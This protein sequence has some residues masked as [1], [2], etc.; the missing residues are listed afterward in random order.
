MVLCQ[1]CKLLQLEDNFDSNEMYGDD[2]GYMSSLNKSMELHLKVK[3]INLIKKYNLKPKNLIL[4]IGSNDGTF[5]SFFNKKFRLFGCDPTIKKFKNLYRK[6]IN[7]LPYFFSKDHFNNKKYNVSYLINKEYSWES[8]LEEASK[9][10]VRCANCHRIKTAIEQ[11]HHTNLL[12][13]EFFDLKK[14]N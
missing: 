11:D 14:N 7:L 4:D 3:S 9:C 2:Y 1:K 5:L 10:E 12:L 13:K 8:I 6:D